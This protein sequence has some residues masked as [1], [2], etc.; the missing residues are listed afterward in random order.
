VKCFPSFKKPKTYKPLPLISIIK[1]SIIDEPDS[2][3]LEQVAQKEPSQPN[4]QT[5]HS[6]KKTYRPHP[7]FQEILEFNKRD[8]P[9]IPKIQST[10]TGIPGCSYQP[11][12]KSSKTL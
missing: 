3:V 12:F 2:S 1:M 5:P 10:Y 11:N 7:D 8:H 6:T 4:F 9:P